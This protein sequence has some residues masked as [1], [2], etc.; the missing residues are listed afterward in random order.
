MNYEFI[1][2]SQYSLDILKSMMSLLDKM[3]NRNDQFNIIMTIKN[4]LKGD[5]TNKTYFLENGGT[6]KFLDIT[7]ESNDMQIVEMCMHAIR[8]QASYK[9][10]MVKIIQI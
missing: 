10:F 2:E 8:E 6:I 1:K 7:L 3:K 9:K 5:K 4:I